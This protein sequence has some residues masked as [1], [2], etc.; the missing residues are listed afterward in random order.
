MIQ[1]LY[2][3]LKIMQQQ[4]KHIFIVIKNVMHIRPQFFYLEF[5]ISPYL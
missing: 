2:L 3:F 5:Q 4:T 1:L